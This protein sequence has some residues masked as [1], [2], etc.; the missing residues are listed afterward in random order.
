MSIDVHEIKQAIK[1][2]GHHW[3]A[4]ENHMTALDETTRKKMHGA[5]PPAD[6]KADPTADEAVDATTLPSSI[7]WRKNNGNYVT[8]VKYQ[9][10]CGSCVGFSATAVFESMIAIEHELPVSQL[11]NSSHML[12]DLSVAD[13]FFCSNH[14]ANCNGWWP[15]DY[16]S[17]NHTRGVVQEN[18]FPFADAFPGGNIKPT[19]EVKITCDSVP[20][21][22]ESA[23]TYTNVHTVNSIN[24]AKAHLAKVGPLAAN[25]KLYTDIFSYKSGI[26]KHTKGQY[27][28]LHCVCIVGYNDNNGDGYWICKNSWGSKWGMQGFFNIGYGQCDMEGYPMFGMSGTT[29]PPVVYRNHLVGSENHALQKGEALVS[30]NG[31]YQLIYQKDGNLVL[32]KTADKTQLWA[33]KTTDKASD[34]VVMQ[35]DG[36]LVMYEGATQVWASN[37]A[38]HPN[39]YLTIQMDGEAIIYHEETP[40]WSTKQS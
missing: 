3:E 10:A 23:F 5:I 28:G 18:L 40:V 34:K 12:I 17:A 22:A 16:F 21:R 11:D 2:K 15:K 33:S 8:Y 7:D 38:G 32:S 20:H 13:A 19:H 9:G 37:T 36:N 4:E 26:Y 35:A 31:H 27:D 1:D 6:A 39:A 14:G 24:A 29:L 30:N 25:L